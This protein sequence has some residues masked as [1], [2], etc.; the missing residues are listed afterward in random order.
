MSQDYNRRDFLKM[1]GVGAGV[2]GLSGVLYLAWLEEQ[3]RL[4]QTFP[5]PS[6]PPTSTSTASVTPEPTDTP[7][8]SDTPTQTAEP[9][10][11]PTSIPIDYYVDSENGD[12]DNDGKSPQ[13]A[14]ASIAKVLSMLQEGQ[15][16]GLASGSHWREHFVVTYNNIKLVAYGAGEKPIIDA[17]D[18]VP[19]AS[20]SKTAGR[21]NVYQISVSPEWGMF[22]WL[23]AWCNDAFLTRADDLASCD[24][25]PG[26]Y[27]PSGLSGTIT[28]YIHPPGSTDPRTDGKTYEYTQRPHSISVRSPIYH[29]TELHGIHARRNLVEVGS[30]VLDKRCKIINCL[31]SDG[32]KHNIY[33]GEGSYLADTICRNAYYGTQNFA[34]F[35]FYTA[36]GT[37]QDVTVINCRAENTTGVLQP[38]GTGFHA[39][40]SGGFL[41]DLYLKN[42]YANQMG[43]VID[44]AY[45]S[46]SIT[47]DGMESDGCMYAVLMQMSMSI[48]DLT[49]SV[50]T[51]KRA[52]NM[53]ASDATL[54]L[55]DST[56]ILNGL[57]ASGGL[58]YSATNPNL[59]VIMDNVHFIGQNNEIC[60]YIGDTGGSI[61]ARNCEFENVSRPYSVAPTGAIDSDNNRFRDECSFELNGVTYNT[62][63]DWQATGHDAHSSI[64]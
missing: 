55:S 57:Y 17:S 6:Y 54:T 44:T 63:A 33:V 46:K 8:P 2:V 13:T 34:F 61:V 31:I 30:V 56:I 10:S 32:S 49:H 5:S 47:I 52:I 29:G 15:T 7:S 24:N 22:N 39:H 62:I 9:S 28:L 37:G 16:V 25:T 59:T 12:D 43:Y 11:T 21:S 18:V 38:N 45:S 4:N 23:N 40:T 60:V 3:R 41:G 20:W 26:S 27:Y 1:L 51:D 14:V 53:F 64:W 50:E 36:E 19:S 35:V 48:R 58:L 42:I